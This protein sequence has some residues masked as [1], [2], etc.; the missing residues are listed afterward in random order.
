[1]PGN[2]RQLRR[3]RARGHHRDGDPRGVRIGSARHVTG[4]VAGVPTA[5]RS[6]TR[7]TAT[8]TIA[9]MPDRT[10]AKFT[11]F[12]LDPAWQRR[13]PE[14]RAEDK[15]EFLAACEDFAQDRS[16]RAYSTV[17]T[18]GDTDLLLLSQSPI[19]EDI[20]TFHV[21]LVAERAR[22][23]D[24][25]P[26]L[27]P[28]DDQALAVLGLRGP[29]RDLHLGPP[30]PVRLPVREEARVVPPPALRAPAD[31]GRAHRDRP[32]LSR[33]SRSTPRT[34]SASTTRSSWSASRPTSPGSSSTWCRSS[35][36]PS[37]APTRCATRRSSPASRCRSRKALDALDGAATARG[38]PVALLRPTPP[39]VPASMSDATGQRREPAA[40]GD[41]RLRAGRLLCGR[42]PAAT[43]RAGRGGGR[44]RPPADPVR[45]RAGGSGARTTRRSSR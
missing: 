29:A 32:P 2:P 41:R 10:F 37:R 20:H 28:G 9:A 30:V 8:T 14:A 34:R 35:A 23:V 19:L 27:L 7:A 33:R 31:H 16:L 17:G 36:G 38:D 6:P 42:A 26:P 5:R 39:R 13:D 40:G 25:D 3:R 21:V 15:R 44:V 1:M 22:E 11:F 18:R 43:G 4:A 24:D 12:K 45:P